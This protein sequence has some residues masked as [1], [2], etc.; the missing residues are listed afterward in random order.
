MSQDS[1]KVIK[2]PI[3]SVGDETDSTEGAELDL[4]G[5]VPASEELDLSD[6]V[7]IDVDE[8]DKSD[9]IP[10]D[11]G[12]MKLHFNPQPKKVIPSILKE[13]GPVA[14]DA[15]QLVGSAVDALDATE[16]DGWSRPPLTLQMLQGVIDRYRRRESEIVDTNYVELLLTQAQR[17]WKSNKPDD[18]EAA[19]AHRIKAL[20]APYELAR[21]A[22]E[23]ARLY[24]A[25][26]TGRPIPGGLLDI[27]LGDKTLWG[28]PDVHGNEWGWWMLWNTRLDDGM[29]LKEKLADGD[30]VVCLGDAIHPDFEPFDYWVP[31]T[32]ILLDTY[33]LKKDYPD[34]FWFFP[35]NHDVLFGGGEEVPSKGDTLQ[36]LL[37]RDYLL[38][39]YGLAFLRAG[40]AFIDQSPFFVRAMAGGETIAGL[41][42]SPVVR[43]GMDV[44]GAIL[45]PYDPIL[46]HELTWNRPFE[47]EGIE[48]TTVQ[49]LKD[50]VRKLASP[51][52]ILCGGHSSKPG[53]P[54]FYRPNGMLNFIIGLAT[55]HFNDDLGMFKIK[56]DFVGIVNVVGQGD[57]EGRNLRK[58]YIDS[59][60]GKKGILRLLDFKGREERPLKAADADPLKKPRGGSCAYKQDPVDVSRAM[61][62][63]KANGDPDTSTMEREDTMVPTKAN[64]AG[65]TPKGYWFGS[66]G[67]RPLIVRLRGVTY[68]ILSKEVEGEA[69]KLFRPGDNFMIVM[70]HGNARKIAAQQT[71][72]YGVNRFGPITIAILS[73]SKGGNVASLSLDYNTS[74]SISM[75]SEFTEKLKDA[76]MSRLSV[77]DGGD[78]GTRATDIPRPTRTSASTAMPPPPPN[79]KPNGNGPCKFK[80]D[81]SEFAGI[82]R[83]SSVA[84]PEATVPEPAPLEISALACSGALESSMPGIDAA[85]VSAML[86]VPHL[87]V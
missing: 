7:P 74:S 25:L 21:V 15:T 40:Q 23:A 37:Y 80:Q 75:E 58:E 14:V 81:A 84:G 31:S 20:Q 67:K 71:L 51:H 69:S 16:G 24:A 33:R 9:L 36:G 46:R 64:G 53:Y 38:L 72:S 39:K 45:S 66:L 29:T 19:K 35:G 78:I 50:T 27:Q 8:S 22:D 65:I 10:I 62:G 42:H 44:A 54:A 77:N 73:D 60:K 83:R 43:G 3:V 59:L 1:L 68:E 61:S 56:S 48:P 26:R 87:R 2:R 13:L 47:Y 32:N 28:I 55:S 79:G 17:L 11:T 52:T 70:R 49:D 85:T 86:A 63:R 5:F 34:R 30:F 4:R 12:T 82:V 76:G 41:A 57:L 18:W 6:L